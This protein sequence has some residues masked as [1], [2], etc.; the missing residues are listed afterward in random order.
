MKALGIVLVVLGTLIGVPSVI[1]C[2]TI[3]LLP[4]G[5]PFLLAGAGLAGLGLHLARGKHRVPTS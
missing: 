5:L 1:A 4:I 2:F 3:V